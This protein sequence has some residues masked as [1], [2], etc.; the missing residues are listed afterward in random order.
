MPLHRTRTVSGRPAALFK[1]G[2]AGLLHP[3]MLRKSINSRS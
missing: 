2:D 3:P 1:V